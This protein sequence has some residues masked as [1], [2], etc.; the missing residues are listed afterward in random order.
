MHA[1][2]QNIEELDMADSFSKN[3]LA[4]IQHSLTSYADRNA[5]CIN[6]KFHTYKELAHGI[7]K[8]RATLNGVEERNIGLVANNDLDTYA[9]IFALW[10]EGKCYVPLHPFQPIDRCEN[11]VR[12]MEMNTIIDSSDDSRYKGVNVIMTQQLTSDENISDVK[13]YPDSDYAYVIF[14]SGSTGLPKGVPLTRGNVAAFVDAFMSIGFKID[15][16]DR[17]LQMFDLT[18]DMSVQSYLT[19][20]LHGACIYTVPS[21]SV[22][23]ME[24]FR[25]IDDYHLTFTTMVPAIIHYMRPYMEEIDAPEMRYSVFAGEALPEDDALA[26]SKCIP[27]AEIIN[28][29]G[30][31]ETTIYCT[32]YPLKPQNNKALNGVLSIGKVMKHTE[33][34]I[35]DENNNEVAMGEEGELCIAGSQLTPGYWKNEDKNASSFFLKDGKRFYRTGDL[36]SKDAEGDMLYYGRKDFQVKIQGFRVELGEIEQ[37]AREFMHGANAIATVV[38]D[39]GGSDIL[40]LCIEQDADTIALTEHLK[41]KLPAYMIPEIIA[42]VPQFPLN[43]NGKIDRKQLAKCCRRQ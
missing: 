4:R 23:Y 2:K 31:T 18:F 22:K 39:D 27:N 41:A 11:I 6:D 38:K 19:P 3:V 10:M 17:C 20:L 1:Q 26:W 7:S 5:V 16:T 24:V 29:Y 12:Q 35:V 33:G 28:L 13:D 30:P 34:M 43:G 21:N 40:G 9:A 36:C 25:L 15:E 42:Y 37:L 32:A 14:T 8:I